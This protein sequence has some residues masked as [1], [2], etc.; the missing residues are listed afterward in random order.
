ML[1]IV[2]T[3][4]IDKKALTWSQAVE[5]LSANPAAIFN[6]AGRG[7]LAAGSIADITI[8]DPEKEYTYSQKDF[9]SKSKNSPY[10]GRKLKGSPEMT[11]VGGKIVWPING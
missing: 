10:I 6:L 11:I 8:I 4:L 7:T 3:E 2:T 5:K 1:G 9:Q